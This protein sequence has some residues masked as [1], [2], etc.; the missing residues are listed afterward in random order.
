M[1]DLAILN[2]VLGKGFDLLQGNETPSSGMK[3]RYEKIKSFLLKPDF[4]GFTKN[5]LFIMQ[6]I[7]KGWGHDIAA[8]SNMAEALANLYQTNQNQ[9]DEYKSLMY[10][11]VFRA[12]HPKVNPY[13]RDIHTV[14]DLGKYGYYLEHL[15]IILGCGRLLLFLRRQCIFFHIWINALAFD[16]HESF[17]DLYPPPNFSLAVLATRS[18]PYV[19][20]AIARHLLSAVHAK[21]KL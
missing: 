18:A 12:L 14:K 5:D 1:F 17:M 21:W 9:R 10:Q 6:F 7:K 11:V 20:Q 8:L 13:K 3:K 15:N 16:A 19:F 4:D 2:G